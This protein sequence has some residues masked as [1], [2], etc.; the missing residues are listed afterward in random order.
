MLHRARSNHVV[1][2]VL[3]LV[4]LSLAS[5]NDILDILE[6]VVIKLAAGAVVRNYHCLEA[7]KVKGEGLFTS[8]NSGVDAGGG[9]EDVEGMVSPHSLVELGLQLL[10]GGLGVLAL[11]LGVQIVQL[12][13]TRVH[14][15]A[16]L[17][18]I[19]SLGFVVFKIS[20]LLS[21]IENRLKEA[22]LFP[23]E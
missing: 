20:N 6:E 4:N 2:K 7:V 17:S 13:V 3:S 15:G 8:L 12:D 16:R 22:A 1:D 18:L 11:D 5:M 14:C 23:P 10:M 21:L 19:N 9:S